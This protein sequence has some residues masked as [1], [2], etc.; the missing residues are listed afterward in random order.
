MTH[1]V[2]AF[3][4]FY[5]AVVLFPFGIGAVHALVATVERLAGL[6]STRIRVARAKPAPLRQ[7]RTRRSGLENEA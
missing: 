7:V 4:S 3:I 1:S 5:V 2:N 6:L